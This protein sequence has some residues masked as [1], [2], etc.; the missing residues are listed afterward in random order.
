[1]SFTYNGRQERRSCETT[2]K[3]LADEILCKI[4]TQIVEGKFFEIG[5]RDT[6]FEELSQDLATDYKIN[7]KRSTDK[8]ERNIRHLSRFLKGMRA[9]DIT[10]GKVQSFI[11]GR[12]SEKA[13]NA[14]INRELAAL[15]R[16]YKRFQDC[17]E[18]RMQGSQPRRQALPR[19]QKDGCA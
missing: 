7:G 2:S 16:A 17:L 6:T 12:Q 11:L 3:K 1:M 10:T 15:K 19:F 18:E 14:T 5:A 4:K 9:A 8:I 13:M